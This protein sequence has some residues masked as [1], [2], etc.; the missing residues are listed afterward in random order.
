MGFKFPLKKP[1]HNT[2]WRVLN[3]IFLSMLCMHDGITKS[4][5]KE[6]L[7]NWNT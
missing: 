4:L 7:L 2:L 3:D 1:L 6:N 5:E